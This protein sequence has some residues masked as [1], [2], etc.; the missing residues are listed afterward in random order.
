M[1]YLT[2]AQAPDIGPDRVR[3]LDDRNRF[4]RDFVRLQGPLRA[5]GVCSAGQER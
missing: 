1:F 4:S 3:V 2:I 5:P